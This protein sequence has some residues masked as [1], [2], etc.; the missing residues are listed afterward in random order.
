MGSLEPQ[1]FDFVKA[2]H[3]EA[4]LLAAAAEVESLFAQRVALANGARDGWAGPLRLDFDSQLNLQER[5][6]ADI[7][8]EMRAAARRILSATQQAKAAQ[9]AWQAFIASESLQPAVNPTKWNSP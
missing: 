9:T 6:A 3:A 5:W 7:A 2:A 1:H 8:S 4:A